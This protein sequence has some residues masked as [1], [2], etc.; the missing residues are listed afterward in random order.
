MHASGDDGKEEDHAEG[1]PHGA[2]KHAGP[3]VP[4]VERVVKQ[5]HRN[6]GILPEGVENHL[7]VMQVIDEK[8]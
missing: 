4:R 7:A 2:G 8:P 6:D 1:G 3:R 5:K